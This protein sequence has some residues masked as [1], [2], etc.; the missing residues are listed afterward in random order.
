MLIGTRIKCDQRHSCIILTSFEA[1]I[2]F[3]GIQVFRWIDI[4]MLDFAVP[5]QRDVLNSKICLSRYRRSLGD[6]VIPVNLLVH[7]G[8]GLVGLEVG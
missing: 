7:I 6:N 1:G 8:R 5:R 2:D 4:L 3:S